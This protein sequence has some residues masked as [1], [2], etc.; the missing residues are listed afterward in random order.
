MYKIETNFIVT[1]DLVAAF[2]RCCMSYMEGNIMVYN[3]KNSEK[4]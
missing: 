2:E 3:L 4:I 1:N